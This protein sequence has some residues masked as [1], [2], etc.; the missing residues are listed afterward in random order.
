MKEN[1]YVR[2]TLFSYG[3]N[4]KE[5]TR[6]NVVFNH[7]AP[8]PTLLGATLNCH[9]QWVQGERGYRDDGDEYL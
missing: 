6:A 4:D 9:A 5:K 3:E 1:R 7:G 8:H 2:R